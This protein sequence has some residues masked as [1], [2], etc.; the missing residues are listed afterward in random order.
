[1]NIDGINGLA[2][3]TPIV[4]TDRST[5]VNPSIRKLITIALEGVYAGSLHAF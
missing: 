5:H 3:L 2:C 1:M 4:K